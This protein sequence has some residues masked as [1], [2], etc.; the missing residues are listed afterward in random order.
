MACG[1][2][3]NVALTEDGRLFQWGSTPQALK[4]KALLQKRKRAND[5]AAANAAEKNEL[6]F[7]AEGWVKFIML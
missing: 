7:N 1:L 4:F 6:P 3:H 2:F 5:A